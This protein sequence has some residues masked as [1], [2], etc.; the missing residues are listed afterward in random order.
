MCANF[1]D[2]C[3][4]VRTKLQDCGIQMSYGATERELFAATENQGVASSNPAG[5]TQLMSQELA[6]LPLTSL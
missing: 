5:V 2:F 6:S 1:S 3:G 4:S